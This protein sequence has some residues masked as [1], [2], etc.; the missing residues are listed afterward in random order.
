M[1][2][3]ASKPA[4]GPVRLTASEWWILANRLTLLCKCSTCQRIA[5]KIGPNG[6]HAARRGVG[7][8][9]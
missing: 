3:K 8:V 6:K 9:K 4:K 7:K 5:D 1:T 2:T